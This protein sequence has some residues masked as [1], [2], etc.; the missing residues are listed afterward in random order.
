L[1][2]F[3]YENIG[4]YKYKSFTPIIV[5]CIKEYPITDFIL[6]K[7]KNKEIV[8]EFEMENGNPKLLNGKLIVLV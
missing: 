8:W 3:N 4:Y 1:K 6:E 7:I 5:D 2:N